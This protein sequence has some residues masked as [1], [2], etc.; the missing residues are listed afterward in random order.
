MALSGFK[1]SVLDWFGLFFGLVLVFSWIGWFGFFGLDWFWFSV[2]LDNWFLIGLDWIWF[3]Q[4][5][6]IGL[7]FWI[8]LVWFFNGLDWFFQRSSALIADC[9]TKVVRFFKL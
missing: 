1:I 6:W 2:G 9:S 7:V 3:F 5:D 4:L 8:G